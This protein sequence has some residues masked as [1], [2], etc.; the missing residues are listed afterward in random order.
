[1][2]DAA[3][4][5]LTEV[6]TRRRRMAA[7]ELCTVFSVI[8]LQIWFW[9]NRSVE[10]TVVAYVLVTGIVC[11][12]WAARGET[13]AALGLGNVRAA[14]WAGL[15]LAAKLVVEKFHL[16]PHL[17][18]FAG[19]CF[20]VGGY[21]VWALLQELLLNGFFAVRLED[22]FAGR[23]RAC[24]AAGVIFAACHF[25]NPALMPITLVWGIGAS[26]IFLRMRRKNLYLL[27]LPH[28]VVG[29][30]LAVL[31]PHF[32]AWHHPMAVGPR[33]WQ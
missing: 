18:V 30:G 21:F 6:R 14:A 22:C 5:S 20:G 10:G 32:V 26:Y 13:L 25:P 9:Q 31:L 12:G 7:I 29:Y 2:Q 15:L 27:T 28:A 8:L 17:T 1:M 33:F 16:F 19:I 11:A 23:L 3:V 24:I 4:I